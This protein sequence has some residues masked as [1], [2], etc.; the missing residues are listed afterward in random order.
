MTCQY[1]HS[2]VYFAARWVLFT[3]CEARMIEF[4]VLFQV[5][6]LEVKFIQLSLE[7]SYLTHLMSSKGHPCP[8]TMLEV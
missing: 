7:N 2:K 3:I 1:D 6:W 4:E 5:G 8:K